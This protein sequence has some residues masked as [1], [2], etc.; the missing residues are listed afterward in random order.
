MRVYT[1]LEW[2]GE[3]WAGLAD[4]GG[5]PHYF[6]IDHSHQG[7]GY[8]VWPVGEAVAKLEREQ[9]AIYARWYERREAGEVGQESHPGHGGVDA[10]YDELGLLLAP[11]RSA[12]DSAR[13]LR[14]ELRFVADVDVRYRVEG[15]D[16]WLRWRPRP[17]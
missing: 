3:P 7:D 2:Y 15:P 8:Q 17:R 6:E 9:W 12:P 1:E 11:H 4:I 14:C 10:R 16:Y 13:R 5:K